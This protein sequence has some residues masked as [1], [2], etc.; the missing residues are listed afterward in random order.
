MEKAPQFDGADLAV[1]I[2]RDPS[3]G[4]VSDIDILE[5]QGGSYYD[6]LNVERT[7]D[8]IGL[9]DSGSPGNKLVYEI[10]DQGLQNQIV[11]I[12]F[13]AYFTS[14]TVSLLNNHKQVIA[15]QVFTCE[16]NLFENKTVLIDKIGLFP[17]DSSFEFV[18]PSTLEYMD[19][20]MDMHYSDYSIVV[21]NQDGVDSRT[22]IIQE[23]ICF[24]GSGEFVEIGSRQSN[25]V[26]FALHSTQAG[27]LKRTKNIISVQVYNGQV[28]L[29]ITQHNLSDFESVNL[30][31]LTGTAS[32]YNGIWVVRVLGVDVI[33]LW[34]A[35]PGD[36][37]TI[38]NFYNGHIY[39]N[40]Y[41]LGAIT[42]REYIPNSDSFKV[43]II[44]KA[45]QLNLYQQK[46][47]DIDIEYFNGQ[48]SAYW[49]DFFSP[50]RAAYFIGE[51]REQMIFKELSPD[52]IYAF[53]TLA[54]EIVCE[55]NSRKFTIKNLPQEQS[56]GN[57]PS[58]TW[59]YTS[60]LE[61]EG[62]AQTEVAPLT[63]RKPVY[64]PAYSDI[65][66]GNGIYGT[67]G[68]TSK[69]NKVTVDGLTPGVY[70]YII[71]IGVYY[72]GADNNAV[73]TSAFEIRKEQL[74][75]DQ[76]SIVLEHNGN[77][78]DIRTFDI[79]RLNV[80]REDALRVGCNVIGENYLLR[81]NIVTT[82]TIDIREWVSKIRYSIK[83][84]NVYGS[85]GAETVFEFYDPETSETVG[86]Q[87]YEWY[88]FHVAAQSRNTGT[89]TDAT[90]CVDVRMLSQADYD[91][92]EFIETNGYDR[93]DMSDD[94]FVDYDLG[95]DQRNFYQYY[96]R[97]KDIDWDFQI[98]GIPAKE[99]F[100]K[101]Y[102][103]R[104][105]RIKE[106]LADGEIR[107]TSS[108][109][110]YN[111][112]NELEASYFE[113]QQFQ[114]LVTEGR[115]FFPFYSPDL[116]FG[117]NSLSAISGD[118]ILS[119]G[120][121]KRS[122]IFQYPNPGIQDSS[123]VINWGMT[124]VVT[125]IEVGVDDVS[126]IETGS[127][128]FAGGFRLIKKVLEYAGSGV[129][130][131]PATY[132]GI[133]P[134][135]HVIKTDA[136]VFNNSDFPD[137][138][139]YRALYF[140][141]RKDKYGSVTS[142]G[143]NVV[144][145]GAEA[146][147]G[148]S[149]V[150]VFGGDVFTQ[151]TWFK[152]QYITDEYPDGFAIGENIISQN[153]INT[154]LRVF[155]KDS[156][157]SWLFPQSSTDAALWLS[158]KIEEAP[159]QIIK[160]S[161]YQAVTQSQFLY[162]YDPAEV[163]RNLKPSRIQ[164]SDIKPNG[165]QTD[166]YRTWPP[167]NFRDNP[168]NFGAI[169]RLDI[170][171][172]ELFTLQERN[173]TRE[174]LSGNGRLG[175]IESGSVIIGDGSVLDRKGLHLTIMGS[176]QP[177]SYARGYTEAGTDVRYWVNDEFDC[178]MRKGPD[179]TV[180]VTER[181]GMSLWFRQRM[182]YV[183]GKS[184]PASGQGVHCIWD[185]IGKNLI[186]TARGWKDSQDWNETSRYD[187]DQTVLYGEEY[188]IPIMYESLQVNP[189]GTG[190]EPGTAEGAAWWRRVS[191]D[192][193]DYYSVFTIVFNEKYNRFQ[194]RYSY[195]PKIYSTQNNRFFSPNPETGK[196][197]RGYLYRAGDP[198][199]YFDIEHEGFIQPILN[200]S[201]SVMKK[202]IALAI[203]AIIKPP[204]VTVETQFISESGID[205]RKTEMLRDS[206]KQITM[207]E[208][209]VFVPIR[210]NLNI[211]GQTNKRTAPMKGL[212]AKITIYFKARE[213][214]KINRIF[215]GV[216]TGQRNSQN[217]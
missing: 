195:Y 169:V 71:L 104:C 150:N 113:R 53:E 80:T 68:P 115:N 109:F 116:F 189:G 2:N 155:E 145:T 214:Q 185:H 184:N 54:E 7:V 32:R 33:A 206:G 46:Q 137:F 215:A 18:P 36:L 130:S 75:P 114:S 135:S 129:S 177:W 50:Q 98:E 193:F 146:I 166:Y 126:Y 57:T 106:V 180:N 172:G 101:I 100:S 25:G 61:T 63:E 173:Y 211:Q 202:F 200:Y 179:G 16:A 34:H 14:G 78:T 21:T 186:I 29:N 188:G 13:D 198:L 192:E 19:V 175:T 49:T 133:N 92:N 194:Q 151:Q 102:I 110:F 212:W 6:K 176:R 22:A 15:S 141:R 65:S 64:G 43:T 73:A 26:T 138:N 37:I 91:P 95:D 42:A 121:P 208:N 41:G 88:R 128:G 47:V 213:F 74:G 207:R 48:Y 83:R 11:R 171:N 45:K 51:I 17:V 217:P 94:D 210:N 183:K 163:A 136:F 77:E 103:C 52:G 197:G 147:A 203:S 39:V 204:K 97:L 149:E 142:S 178:L 161:A 139:V 181:C 89:T 170:M 122:Q 107:I 40:P 62:G 9:A 190:T 167:L 119:F 187:K 144:Y 168:L 117:V 90:F 99:L 158:K 148:E 56:G 159:D 28:V 125:P 35:V 152:R 96:L 124:S 174:F 143:S 76:T 132:S 164:Y 140:R 81:G 209:T 199:V 131:D 67:N 85:Y 5:M 70:K 154:N 191:I 38:P 156:L 59:R 60:I 79:R 3:G 182:R 27:L 82:R 24:T 86:Y 30:S 118:K 84:F 12:Y 23:A 205:N 69:I 157:T 153:G 66:T 31:N 93:R 108:S 216:R 127:E 44:G 196:Q 4:M 160:N 55:V 87:H 8:G 162:V 10:P 105:E 112:D 1:E 134:G 123:W 120:S 165:S 111:N 201:S 72:A 20:T 58:G